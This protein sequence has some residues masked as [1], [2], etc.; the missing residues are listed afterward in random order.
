[1]YIETLPK[2][3]YRFAAPVEE[4]R[5]PAETMVVEHATTTR[6]VI[7]ETESTGWRLPS[8]RVTAVILLPAIVAATLAYVVA[9]RNLS[10]PIRSLAVLPLK[11]LAGGVDRRYL[12]LGIADSI[13]GKV[14]AISG[15]TV[16][17]TG[18]VRGYVELGTDPL[19]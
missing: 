3:G 7:E 17:P 4:L 13:I 1:R 10:P 9:R 19:R 18:A 8:M 16:R 6:V 15:L 5:R 11:D 12:E 14:S 2:R